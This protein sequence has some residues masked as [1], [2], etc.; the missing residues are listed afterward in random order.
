MNDEIEKMRNMLAI[1]LHISDAMLAVC[2]HEGLEV[3]GMTMVMK[4]NETGETKEVETSPRKVVDWIKAEM[5]MAI[6]KIEI[7]SSE[8]EK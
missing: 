7:T 2:E 3:D 4:H 8:A 1:M 6:N 5:G